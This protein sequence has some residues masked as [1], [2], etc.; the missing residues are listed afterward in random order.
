[1]QKSTFN[2]PQTHPQSISLWLPGIYRSGK[3]RGMKWI[4]KQ[5]PWRC[6]ITNK[7]TPKKDR[8]FVAV[9]H[10]VIVSEC[11]FAFNQIVGAVWEK[12]DEATMDNS[13]EDIYS[14]NDG[15]EI[16]RSKECL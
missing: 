14:P 9:I 11:P 5:C 4:C 2:P 15:E 3:E 7:A 13:Q 16:E 12:V 1:M 8:I 10:T 6:E